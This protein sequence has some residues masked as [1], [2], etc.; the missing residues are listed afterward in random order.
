MRDSD[1]FSWYMERDPVLRS[2]V[3]AV[4]WLEHS[5]DWEVLTAKLEEA[6]RRIPS[7]RQ[8][9]LEPPARLSTP[10]WT[11][12]EEFDLSWHLR[13]VDAPAPHNAGTVVELARYEASTA[14]D[15]SRPLWSFTLVEHF[16]V[17]RAALI[18]KL[19][20]SL[21]DGIGG[22]QL[23]LL[24]F[25]ADKDGGPVPMT[26][27]A[28]SE[29]HISTSELVRQSIVHEGALLTRLAVGQTRAFVP[30]TTRAVRHPL[31]SASAVL[32]T[33]RSIGR[34]VAPARTTLSPI[35]TDRGLGRRLDLLEVGLDDLKRASANAGG[36]INDGFMAAATGG[37]RRYHERH[38]SPV[39]QLRV[40]MPMS[41][42]GPDDP[43]GGNRITLMRFTVPVSEPDPVRRIAVIGRR[44][45]AAR[46]EKSLA[47]TDAIAGTLNLLPSGVVGS[48][49]KHVDFLASDV[50]GF[51]FPL[52]LGG[53][54]LERLVSFS[55]TIGASMNLTLLSYNGTCFIGV[56]L[57]TVAVPD[58]DVL[59]DCLREGFEEVLALAG[60]HGPVRLLHAT[61]A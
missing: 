34:T 33:A 18:M 28:P 39:E 40:T 10:R 60:A 44:C 22:M 9:V 35:M 41:I 14:F 21:T 37:L 29:P 13:R 17:D 36:T 11:Y 46:G 12:D 2:T 55:P 4:A 26:T 27:E 50:P 61:V 57:D 16:D 58:G 38:G 42:R 24:L 23:A 25:D 45:R 32:E 43:L 8:R 7:F 1:A 49:L 19:H 51:S 30:R 54:R 6:T 47:W 3:V 53:A 52:Y 56:T 59:I 5:P 20:H 31:R 48:M 15:R